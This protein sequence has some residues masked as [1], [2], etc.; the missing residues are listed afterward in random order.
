MTLFRPAVCDVRDT[1]EMPSPSLFVARFFLLVSISNYLFDCLWYVY[2]TLYYSYQHNVLC[3]H[4][5]YLLSWVLLLLTPCW[6]LCEL[7][8]PL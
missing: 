7:E 4:L 6:L 3:E 1:I 5:I 8:S 2:V